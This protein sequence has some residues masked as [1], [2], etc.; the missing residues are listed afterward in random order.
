MN[1]KIEIRCPV[2]SFYCYSITE[3]LQDR[4]DEIISILVRDKKLL[5]SSWQRMLKKSLVLVIK[6]IGGIEGTALSCC[7]YCSISASTERDP[8]TLSKYMYHLEM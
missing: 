6:C 2:S 4:Y 7:V 8:T 1:E 3:P 5:T